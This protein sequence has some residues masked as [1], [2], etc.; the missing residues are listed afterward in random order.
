MTKQIGYSKKTQNITGLVE[1]ASIHSNYYLCKFNYY[2]LKK[3]KSIISYLAPSLTALCNKQEWPPKD[4]CV[5]IS[6]PYK[7]YFA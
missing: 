3:Q 2:T 7:Y 1:F 4:A 5:L 6:G